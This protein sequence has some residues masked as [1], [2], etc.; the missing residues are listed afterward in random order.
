MH[1][2]FVNIFKSRNQPSVLMGR[3]GVVA[4]M[5]DTTYNNIYITSKHGR[6]RYIHIY[7]FPINNYVYTENGFQ[8][9]NC[10]RR[11]DKKLTLHMSRLHFLLSYYISAFEHVTD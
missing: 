8:M 3:K 11:T 9:I 1:Y 2:I 10:A 5:G 4:E 6:I 7:L